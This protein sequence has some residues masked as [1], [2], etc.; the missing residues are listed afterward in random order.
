[1]DKPKTSSY[2]KEQ[3]K[4]WEV[5]T[6]YE[7]IKLL[8]KGSYGSVV[9]AIQLSTGKKVAIKKMDS[10]FDDLTDCK[11]ILREIKLLKMLKY[12][13]IVE[14]IDVIEPKNPKTFNSLYIVLEFCQSDLKKVIKSAIF[15]KP[16]HI[17][18]VIYNLLITLNFIHTSDVLHRDIKP[19]NI[20]INE[21]CSIKLCDFGLARS[22]AG[23][24]SASI[25]L[26]KKT[27]KMTEEDKL[28]SGDEDVDLKNFEEAPLEKKEEKKKKE[29]QEMT[30]KLMRSKDIRKNMKRVLT[31]HVVTRWYRAPEL[32]LLEKDYGPA[33]DMWSVGCIFAELLSM[34]KENAPTFMDRTPL[35]PGS[36]CFPLSPDHKAKINTQ[37]FPLSS[38]D[39]LNVI[40]DIIGTPSEE[41]LSFVTDTKAIEYLKSFHKRP[42]ADL[43]KMYP[44]ADPAAIDLLMKMLSFNPYFRITVNEALTHPYISK[45][46]IK[47]KEVISEKK[48]KLDFEKAAELTEQTLRDLFLEEV[49]FFKKH[50]K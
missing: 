29:I 23:V 25:F 21:D 43:S 2:A 13:G 30:K 45:I 9:E 31:G 18:T 14:L 1:M 17:Q 42:K 27:V 22:I 32:I 35:F 7:L 24:V 50:K 5:G 6:D 3:F 26:T 28:T 49:E 4:S 11:R 46:R 10:V 16:S 12:P 41:D 48:I 44:A 40:F 8:G 19:A 38:T 37:G 36:S 20:L 33:I 15:L 34:I 47:E 39:Q